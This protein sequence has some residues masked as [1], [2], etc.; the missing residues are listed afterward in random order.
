MQATW[1]YQKSSAR[2]FS[3]LEPHLSDHH[4]ALLVG[5]GSVSGDPDPAP[6][7]LKGILRV[8]RHVTYTFLATEASESRWDWRSVSFSHAHREFR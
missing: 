3:R 1:V 2:L 7:W 5:I 8:T 6:W 4:P